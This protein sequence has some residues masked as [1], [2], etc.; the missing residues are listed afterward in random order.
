[1]DL[2]LLDLVREIGRIGDFAADFKRDCADLVRRISLLS[3]LLEE[4]RDFKHSSSSSSGVKS[5]STSSS[6][7]SSSSSPFS[8]LIELREL[9]AVL[10]AANR[11]L[12]LGRS[13][14]NGSVGSAMKRIT[15]LFQY[16][17]WHLE[18]VLGDFPYDCF[19][20]SDEVREQVE[21]VRAQLRRATAR[22]GSLNLKGFAVISWIFSQTLHI[23]TEDDSLVLTEVV[24]N[25]KIE[26]LGMVNHDFQEMVDMVA[27]LYVKSGTTVERTKYVLDWFNNPAL[28]NVPKTSEFDKETDNSVNK[29]LE[30]IKKPDSLTIPDDFRCPISLELMR[31]PIIVATGQTYERSFIQRWI[32][33]GNQTC[34]KTQQKL[35]NLTLTT[36]YVLRSLIMQWCEAHRI[37]QPL[38][39]ASGRIRKSD[40]SFH[41]VSGDSAAINALVRKLSSPSID[42]QRTAISE[43]RLLAKRSTDNRVLIAET[44]AIPLLVNLLAKD[45]LQMQ[46]NAVTAIL[47]LSIYESNKG[48][49]MLAGAV[50]P[51][52]EVLRRG[53]M[54]ARENA[55]ATLF[56]LSL[57]DENKIII[58]A[59][60]AI[61]ALVELLNT[62]SIRGKKDAATALFNLCIYHENKGRAVRAGILVPLMNMLI[63]TSNGMVDEALTIL[64][65]LANSKECKAAIV[66]ANAIPVLIDLIRTGLPRNK[67]NAAAILLSLCKKDR[68][69]LAC[70]GRLGAVIPL[71]ELVRSGTDRAKRKATSVL[72]HLNR[73]QQQV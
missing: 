47:N 72:E 68:E 51:I 11:L 69:N 26:K 42:E 65:V 12:L 13:I 62:G 39:L 22:N 63:D 24:G 43:I 70:I 19:E 16:V 20:I 14:G 15:F 25:C 2:P 36:N 23:R 6:F 40:G 28:S 4:I 17:T 58:G 32:D 59:S 60:G 1:M 38:G 52:V 5:A 30:E 66:K 49:I 18:K 64:S 9:Q 29:S 55:A 53:S 33:C 41:E 8:C 3:H 34:P 61:K 7:S 10:E 27:E 50:P 44:G 54:E 67:E 37:E 45:D 35:E 46:E 21:L 73:S 57:I 71:T 56:S 31:D 48:L